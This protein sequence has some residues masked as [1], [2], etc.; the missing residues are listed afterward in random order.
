M[1][2]PC[3]L[4]GG[5]AKPHLGLTKMMARKGD[6]VGTME[7]DANQARGCRTAGVDEN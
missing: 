5:N 3:R 2:A 1:R 6:R 7:E 4:A